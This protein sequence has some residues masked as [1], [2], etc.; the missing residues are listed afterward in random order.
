M[1]RVIVT[2]DRTERGDTTVLLDEQIRS[3]HL[4]TDHSARQ[5]VERLGW[6]ISD[7]EELPLGPQRLTR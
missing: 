4:N 3:V 7:A 6:A 5:F 2:T 1:P